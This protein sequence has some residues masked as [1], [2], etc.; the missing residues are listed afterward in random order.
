MLLHVN[1]VSEIEYLFKR[2]YKASLVRKRGM[3][4]K[5]HVTVPSTFH[6]YRHI[7]CVESSVQGG[8]LW[9]QTMLPR[10]RQF[11][12]LRRNWRALL[13]VRFTTP[14]QRTT[15]CNSSWRRFARSWRSDAGGYAIH[16]RSS[17]KTGRASAPKHGSVWKTGAHSDRVSVWVSRRAYHQRRHWPQVCFFS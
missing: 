15:N 1:L 12:L 8:L 10:A 16:A 6:H 17:S 13:R 14:D 5:H 3:T 4:W 2:L 7:S 9:A 11:L